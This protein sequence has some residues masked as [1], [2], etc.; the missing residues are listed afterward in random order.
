M[1]GSPIGTVFFGLKVTYIDHSY[2]H[3]RT[4][5]QCRGQTLCAETM[6]NSEREVWIIILHNW[7][8]AQI[9]GIQ[10][11][12]QVIWGHNLNSTEIL[13]IKWW[14]H[15]TI[16]GMIS[17]EVLSVY[18]AVLISKRWVVAKKMPYHFVDS[19]WLITYNQ[20]P[21]K[22]NTELVLKSL[23]SCHSVWPTKI[24][25]LPRSSWQIASK[26]LYGER[27]S[28]INS[29]CMADGF[30]LE[31]NNFMQH[32]TSTVLST[33]VVMSLSA[34]ERHIRISARSTHIVFDIAGR[35]VLCL[36]IQASGYPLPHEIVLH[37]TSNLN[38]SLINYGSN[39]QLIDLVRTHQHS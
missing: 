30:Y 31:N 29:S 39:V 22:V 4:Q 1:S 2:E 13:T 38:S 35:V 27:C 12:L 5:V 33:L 9:H 11:K 20:L 36:S 19:W 18:L 34:S 10:A 25:S 26:I 37:M 32:L 28:P 21:L 14:T 24:S 16:D 15:S 6:R 17:S 3:R 8:A 7:N 23:I